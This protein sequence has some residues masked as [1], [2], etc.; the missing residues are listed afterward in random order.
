MSDKDT[1]RTP[2]DLRK[3]SDVLGVSAVDE[4]GTP[5]DLGGT[6]VDVS[7]TRNDLSCTRAD[8][9]GTIEVGRISDEDRGRTRFDPCA[10]KAVLRVGNEDNA[11]ANNEG[12]AMPRQCS[13]SIL[14]CK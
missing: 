4:A 9:S 1:T 8:L 7:G 10:S 3:S 13:W 12:R 5:A 6:S 2:F 14:S 11:T